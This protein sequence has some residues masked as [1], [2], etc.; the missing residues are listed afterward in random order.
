M[1]RF[2][3][4]PGRERSFSWLV[5]VGTHGV[6]L[7]GHQKMLH[8]E[9]TTLWWVQAVTGFAL[10]FLASVHLYQMLMHPFED[11]VRGSDWGADWKIDKTM[12]FI[13]LGGAHSLWEGGGEVAN[14]QEQSMRTPDIEMVG[15]SGHLW[16]LIFRN[17]PGEECPCSVA[18]RH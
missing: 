1:V 10:F 3:F 13:T 18:S 2:R 7:H 8:H 6:R 5:H 16:A 17:W 14:D 12:N 9:D 11:T 15:N 4:R